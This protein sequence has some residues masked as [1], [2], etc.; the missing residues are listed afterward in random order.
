MTYDE[1][2][3]QAFGGLPGQAAQPFDYQRRLAHESWPDL[4]E[5]P[6]GMGKTAAVTL[7]WMWKRGRRDGA[8]GRSPD[9]ATPRRL[10]W[11]LPMRG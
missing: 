5:V 6:T 3:Q 1:F 4:V 11:C 10:V 8:R 9:I 2:F 7:A